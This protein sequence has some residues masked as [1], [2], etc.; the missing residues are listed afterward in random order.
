MTKKQAKQTRESILAIA[1]GLEFGKFFTFAFIKAELTRKGITVNTNANR[2]IRGVLE[3]NGFRRVNRQKWLPPRVGKKPK[4]KFTRTSTGSR[5]PRKQLK[6]SSKEVDMVQ[7]G[8]SV[9]AFINHLKE[10]VTKAE[11]KL[12]TEK[13]FRRELV[14]AHN[15]RV[16]DLNSK[17]EDLDR[18]LLFAQNSNGG[19]T[20]KLADVATV[21]RLPRKEM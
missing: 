1:K 13:E 14:K 19:K 18:K 12:R 6:R 9:L 10:Q 5:T 17:I 3:E 2:L 7:L 4:S 8:E 20:V 16:S 15:Q 11:D 21:R